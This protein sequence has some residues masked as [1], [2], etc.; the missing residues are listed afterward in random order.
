M[1]IKNYDELIKLSRLCETIIDKLRVLQKYF[2]ENVEYDYLLGM[3]LILNGSDSDFTVF[4]EG[5]K[6]ILFLRK[7]KKVY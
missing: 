1:E 2:L 3:S 4:E 7:K 6:L 5:K